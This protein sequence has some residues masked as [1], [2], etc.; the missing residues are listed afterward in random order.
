MLQPQIQEDHSGFCPSF[1][2]LAQLHTFHRVL[3]GPWEYAQLIHMCFVD[4]EKAFNRVPHGIM[5]EVLLEYQA[6]G[7]G[8]WL[9]LLAVSQICV[10]YIWNSGMPF[11]TGSVQNFYGQNF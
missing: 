11:I 3:E 4:L 9:A 8:A 7:A 1:G 5:W 2:T 10:W 6:Q